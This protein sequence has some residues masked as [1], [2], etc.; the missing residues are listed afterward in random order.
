MSDRRRF[1]WKSGRLSW[2]PLQGFWQ[3][4][5]SLDAA[6]PQIQNLP[7]VT[8]SAGGGVTADVA[9]TEADDTAAIS[10][11]LTLTASLGWTEADDTYSLAGGLTVTTGVAW[12]EA[13][14]AYALVVALTA[15]VALAWTES[16]DSWAIT[17]DIASDVVEAAVSWTEEDDTWALAGSIIEEVSRNTVGGPPR[18]YVDEEWGAYLPKPDPYVVVEV[19]PTASGVSMVEKA[20][21]EPRFMAKRA[22]K[23]QH[24]PEF[25][26]EDLAEARELIERARVASR[27][28]RARVLLLLS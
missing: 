2:S 19:V 16:D 13:D 10:G 25:T 20:A 9:W 15:T 7:L 11:A 12:V 1:K 28:R 6:D 26:D 27:N 24:E 14:D 17:G 5:E 4:P 18:V 8:A 23:F 3:L 21:P 22:T